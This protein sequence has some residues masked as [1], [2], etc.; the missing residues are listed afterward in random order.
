MH[1]LVVNRQVI[2]YSKIP[3]YFRAALCDIKS[4]IQ[5]KMNGQF[6]FFQKKKI[7]PKFVYRHIWS[8]LREMQQQQ[9]HASPTLPILLTSDKSRTA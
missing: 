8:I 7:Q 6:L 4:L 5:Q 3:F 1:T 2:E 9:I